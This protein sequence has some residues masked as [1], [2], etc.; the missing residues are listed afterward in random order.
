[1]WRAAIGRKLALLVAAVGIA[2]AAS[3]YRAGPAPPDGYTPHERARGERTTAWMGPGA[4]RNLAAHLQALYGFTVQPDEIELAASTRAPAGYGEPVVAWFAAEPPGETQRD[5][6]ALRGRMSAFGVPLAV[7]APV[8]ITRTPEGDEAL[9]DAA[10]DRVLY[11]TRIGGRFQNA[12]A[13]DFGRSWLPDGAGIAARAVASLN[14]RQMYGSWDGPQR[15]D[16]LLRRPPPILHGK[17]LPG[18]RVK[19]V[20]GPEDVVEVHLTTGEVSDPERARLLRGAPPQQEVMSLAADT[21]RRSTL[22]G[23]ERVMAVESVLFAATD[24][25]R[26]QSHRVFPTAADRLP[27]AAAGGPTATGGP[28]P[29]TTI[30][31]ERGLPSEG[32]WRKAAPYA[33]RSTS[34]VRQ[35]FLRVDAE[36]PYQ[37]TELFA[38]DTRRLSLHFVGGTRHP[39]STTGARG[40]GRIP[41]GARP[42][43]VAAFNGAFKVEHGR[44]GAVEGGLVLVPPQTGLATVAIDRRGRAAFGEWDATRFG[45]PWF[46]LRQNLRP[47]VAAGRVNPRR[48]RDW[49]EVVASLDDARTPR[50]AVGLT[51]DGVLVYAWS[52]ATSARLLGEAMR[53]AGV[54]F[55]MHLDMN[56]GHTG[57]E[58]Y[59][60]TATGLQATPGAPEMDFRPRRWLEVDA[61]DFFYLRHAGG[62][63]ETVA[64]DHPARGEGRWRRIRTDNRA[65]R[66]AQA[67]ISG[68]RLGSEVR[69]LWAD[70]D[71]VSARVVP[72]LAEPRPK[73]GVP[74]S[75]AWLD[76][77]PAAWIDVGLRPSFSAYGLVADRRVWRPARPGAWTLAVD[78]QGA[79]RIGRLG[80]ALPLQT[81]WVHL[82]QGPALLEDAR[83]T[84]A[85]QG[86]AGLPL[87]AAGQT[88]AGGLL[89]ATV[90]DG[91]RASLAEALRLAGVRDAVL[92]GEQGTAETGVARFFQA[93][94]NQLLGTDGVTDI[95]RPTELATG[96][97][98]SLVL[99]ARTPA[100]RARIVETFRSDEM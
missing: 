28:W 57:V 81:E 40:T 67:W 38:F 98:T 93:R 10:E 99:V 86:K 82:V 70:A 46:D 64:L 2:L 73:T 32:E 31:A 23:P 21:L 100:P 42:H 84:R 97:G 78:E 54:Q 45:E 89:F 20:Y 16:V 51:A 56:P 37:R 27:V 69:L 53:R 15:V 29:P 96:A 88:A 91:D 41:D 65:P 36:R 66:V 85:A 11:A 62:A 9:L 12:V 77:A 17:F 63:P 19:L 94:G 92:L 48:V 52:S 75:D 47:L 4:R 5:V 83:L 33:G 50:S 22:V 68:Q 18:G 39:R 90:S 60:R 49:G 76:A 87:V 79:T 1:M 34:P 30:P 58:L 6:F 7:R 26:R 72:G 13:L 80:E 43:L 55:A 3:Y 95:F 24:W 25:M 61:R 71:R 8:N 59:Q 74:A 44:F 35:S 14:A